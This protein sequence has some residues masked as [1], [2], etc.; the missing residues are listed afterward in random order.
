ML[1]EEL[2]VGTRLI[3]IAEGWNI[4]GTGSYNANEEVDLMEGEHMIC[5]DQKS[6]Q[7][8]TCDHRTYAYCLLNA[9]HTGKHQGLGIF[10][11]NENEDAQGE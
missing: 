6:V 11:G 8:D 4:R 2:P 9:G 10:W 1:L 5:N 7:C 3:R